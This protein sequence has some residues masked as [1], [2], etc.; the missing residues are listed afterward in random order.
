MVEKENK[1]IKDINKYY[2]LIKD[3]FKIKRIFL[4]GSYAN[5][6]AHKDSDIDIGI[7]IEGLENQ[8]EI[9]VLSELYE[10]TKKVNTRIEPLCISYKQYRKPLRASILEGIIKSG[11]VVV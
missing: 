11:V 6:T 2:R 5:G 7:V 10:K 8:N 9:K 4:Y 1:I 3:S